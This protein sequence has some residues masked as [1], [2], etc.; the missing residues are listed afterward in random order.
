MLGSP[1]YSTAVDMWSVGC[2]MAEMIT[3]RPLF[4]GGAQ[5]DQLFRVFRELGTPNEEIWP[6]ISTL[7]DFNPNFPRKHICPFDLNVKFNKFFYSMETKRFTN[8]L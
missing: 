2:I 8:F 4:P 3:L 1:H 5:I 7:P 6:G